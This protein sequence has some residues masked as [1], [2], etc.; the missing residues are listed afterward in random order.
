MSTRKKPIKVSVLRK[1]LANYPNKHVAN[2][3]LAGFSE[4]FYLFFSCLQTHTENRNLVSAYQHP[5][6]LLEKNTN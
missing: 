1:Y 3:L 6:G 2:K 5:R 4:G